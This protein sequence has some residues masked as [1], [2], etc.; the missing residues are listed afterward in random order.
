MYKLI[1]LGTDNGTAISA[2]F[3]AIDLDTL[4]VRSKGSIRSRE[5]NI[6]HDTANA[7]LK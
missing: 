7:I 3:I 6:V 4:E 2:V 5:A 1:K